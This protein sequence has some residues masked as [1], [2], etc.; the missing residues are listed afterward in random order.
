MSPSP[1]ICHA[2]GCICKVGFAKERNFAAV[3][4]LFILKQ[5]ENMYSFIS[6][7]YLYL[8]KCVEDVCIKGCETVQA[9]SSAF[10]LCSPPPN[11]RPKCS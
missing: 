3:L 2:G 7:T 5:P 8:C 9:H 4:I 11:K 10:S 1:E 6:E